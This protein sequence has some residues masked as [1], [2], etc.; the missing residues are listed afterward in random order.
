M[1][2]CS[3]VCQDYAVQKYKQI[4]QILHRTKKITLKCANNISKLCKIMHDV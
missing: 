4:M 3:Q 1:Q 2:N